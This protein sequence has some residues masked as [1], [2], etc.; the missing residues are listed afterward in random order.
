MRGK[1]SLKPTTKTTLN[2]KKILIYTILGGSIFSVLLYI[3]LTFFGIIGNPN[4]ALAA[5]V[6]GYSWDAVITIDQTKVFGQNN[7][8]DFP[9][10][11]IVTN[12]VLKSVANGGRVENIDGFD[13]V[14]S[15]M[16]D[17]QLDHQIESYNPLT[18]EYV[19]W[20]KLPVL[21]VASNTEF[22]MFYGNSIITTDP[23]TTNAWNA[24]YEAVWHMNNDPTN[25]SP[26]LKDGTIHARDGEA[27]GGMTTSD[28]V[29]GKIGSAIELDGNNDYYKISGY[30]GV[31]GITE[32][33][34]SLWLKSNNTGAYDHRLISW[35]DKKKGKKYDIGV[36]SNNGSLRVEIGGGQQIGSA[37]ISDGNWHYL[38][39]VLPV[40]PSPN[41]IDH[42]L[43][44]DGV[45]ENISNGGNR[46]LNTASKKKV[47]I[48]KSNF[49]CCFTDGIVDEVRISSSALTSGWIATEYE[50][51]YSPSTFYTIV[52]G[53]SPLPVE[54]TSFNA[55][56]INNRVEITWSTASEIN[57][58][59]F[60]IEKSIDAENYEILD[61][62]TGAGNSQTVINYSYI[63]YDVY[64]DLTY[65]RLKQ[66][67]FD[68]KFEYF[69]PKSI[70]N[71][72][73]LNNLKIIKV[74]PNPFV[75]QFTIEIQSEKSD[76]IDFI[77]SNMNGITVFSSQINI[78]EGR[79]EYTFNNGNKLSSGTYILNL[80]Q[81]GEK[82]IS[83]K[84]IKK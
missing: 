23:S 43:Y 18:G 28:L 65:Y 63:D 3:G 60:T 39:F 52:F 40:N 76:N 5:Q 56:L 67:D 42:I 82:P 48:G 41:V 55:E 62:V 20:V 21:S 74:K 32:R 37:N 30:K 47:L 4:K 83:I 19:A 2:L 54:L 57:N 12:P 17:N 6:T 44:V 24:N 75:Y 51:Q 36:N 10:A 46:A 58:D 79:T 14:F 25:V 71:Q 11:V 26:Q 29:I 61:E 49:S 27:F 68:G 8:I 80:I 13:I 84:I 16:S 66:T 50:N 35:G 33:T 9:V 77:L 15:D 59:Y 34:V 53:V 70:N 38:T 45:V 73:E 1:M 22:K 69:P 72:T 31:T 64:N 81:E 78:E 7:L